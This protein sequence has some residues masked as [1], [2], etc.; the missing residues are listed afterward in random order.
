MIPNRFIGMLLSPNSTGGA[1]STTPSDRET[2]QDLH[3]EM[4]LRHNLP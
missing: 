2:L 4:R 3:S 1:I